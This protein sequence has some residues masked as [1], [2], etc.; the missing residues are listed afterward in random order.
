M[1][2]RSFAHPFLGL[3]ALVVFAACDAQRDE[4]GAI[5]EAGDV[6]VFSIQI[7]DCFDDADDGEV[8]EVGG[9]PC[10]EPHDNEVYALFDLVDDA[11]PGDEAVNETAGAGCRERFAA[12]IGADY[13]DSILMFYPMTPTQGSWDELDDREVV[14]VAYHMEQEKLTGSVLG[15]GM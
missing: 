3:L 15:S 13:E 12:A 1:F 9:I 6:S 11:W 2:V 4:S 7:G 14:C 10:S 5:S 8:M